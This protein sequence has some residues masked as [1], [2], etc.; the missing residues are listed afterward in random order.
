MLVGLQAGTSTMEVSLA[1]PQKIEHSTTRRSS[2]TSPGHIPRICCN[3]SE[4]HVLHYFHR[5]LI[6]NSKKVERTQISFNRG[7]DTENVVHYTMEYYSATKTNK[8]MKF[9]GKWMHL[10]D[11]ILSEVTQSQKYTHVMHSLVSGY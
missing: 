2:N 5:S 10:E 4:G 3:I 9:L 11:I 8:F 1:V 6:Y 7:I